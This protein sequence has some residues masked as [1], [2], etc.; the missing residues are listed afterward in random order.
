MEQDSRGR[1]G[2]GSARITLRPDVGDVNIKQGT[3][4]LPAPSAP[5]ANAPSN[6]KQSAY[7]IHG[8]QAEVLQDSALHSSVTQ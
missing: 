2:S 3:A 8:A 1:I 6:P 4:F 7:S 5:A